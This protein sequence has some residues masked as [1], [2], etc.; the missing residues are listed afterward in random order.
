VTGMVQSFFNGYDRCGC[1]CGPRLEG[2]GERCR[3]CCTLDCR[4]TTK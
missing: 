2:E 4:M 1:A 3:T